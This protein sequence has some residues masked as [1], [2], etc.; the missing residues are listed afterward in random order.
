MISSPS[1]EYDRI[2]RAKR[3]FT[4]RTS[5]GQMRLS[6]VKVTSHFVFP[7]SNWNNSN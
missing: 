2:L 7:I 6:D 3:D 4:D 1:C 5:N